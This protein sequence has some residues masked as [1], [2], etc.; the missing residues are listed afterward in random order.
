V[1]FIRARCGAG[2]NCYVGEGGKGDIKLWELKAGKAVH[3]VTFEGHSSNVF[4]LRTS[5]DVLYSAS[6]DCTVKVRDR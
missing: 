3:Y 1:R 4:C 6:G 2:N 5:G